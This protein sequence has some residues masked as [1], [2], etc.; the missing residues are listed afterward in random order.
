MQFFADLGDNPFLLAGLGAGLL[1]SIACGVMGPFV[2]AK[3]IVFLAGAI[4]H[5]AIGG[6]G[7]VIFLRYR[8]PDSLGELSPISGAIVVSVLAAVVLAVLHHRIREQ[9]DTIVGALWALGMAIG[10]LLVKI[11]PG[12]Q[13][14][15]MSYLFGNLVFV[16]PE[17]LWLMLVMDLIIVGTV[18]IFYKRFFAVCLDPEQATL[19]GIPVLVTEIVL[20]VL[21]ALTVIVLT[22]IVGLI[23][24]DRPG[25]P[26]RRDGWTA[27]LQTG[28]RDLAID[29]NLR[30]SD[31]PATSLGLWKLDQPR[32]GNRAVGGT[33]LPCGCCDT[34]S[35]TKN[36]RAMTRRN[37][38]QRDAILGALEDADR[39][40]GHTEILELAQRNVPRLG[41]ATVYRNVRELVDAGRIRAVRLPGSPDRYE[42]AGKHHHHHFHCRECDRVFEL[43]DCTDDYSRVTPRGF[44]LENHEVTLYG[45]CSSCSVA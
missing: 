45:L 37:T 30:V 21:V 16:S 44:R 36:R 26:P 15:L 6:I 20:L 8:F 33:A 29:R 34:T 12:Y 10:I 40:L 27:G 2:V 1:A 28:L 19:Q 4:A 31:D 3:R 43:E 13:T 9:L 42:L 18:V 24:S 38:R 14:E 5:I 25:Q 32:A 39:P 22:Q 41:I 17:S 35:K 11:T 23:L 7:A